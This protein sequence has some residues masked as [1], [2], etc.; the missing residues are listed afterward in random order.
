[1]RLIGTQLARMHAADVVHGD[2]TT[3]NMM[4]RE[5]APQKPSDPT[6]QSDEKGDEKRPRVVSEDDELVN[7]NFPTTFGA[8]ERV[9]TRATR[10][11]CPRQHPR[12]KRSCSS[13][14]LR[15]GDD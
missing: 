2:L 15:A 3:S 14:A 5:R 9:C 12:K 10:S 4:L 13:F 1:M 7:K 11:A 8:Q 6:I